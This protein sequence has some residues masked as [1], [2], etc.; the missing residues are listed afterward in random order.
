MDMPTLAT[1]TA[2][3]FTTRQLLLIDGERV[4]SID[5][6]TIEVIDPAT[7][8][9][10]A[11]VAEARAA[12]IDRAVAAARKSFAD[13]RWRGLTGDARARVLLRFAELI[14][15]HAE[16]LA[17]IDT[18][19]NGMPLYM[20]RGAVAGAALQLRAFAGATTRIVGR[21]VS[22]AISLPGEY[23]AYTRR[24]PVGVVGLI[25]PWNGPLPTLITKLAPALASGC[26]LVVKPSEI[27]PLSA[28]RVGELALEA[29]VPA[30]VLNVVP[31]VGGDAGAA[32]ANHGDINKISFT[33]STA[34]GKELV[35]ASAGNLKRI[36]LELGGKSP[37]IVFDDA[38]MAKAIPGAAMSVFMNSGQACIAGSRLFV[39]RKAFDKVVDG[40]AQVA[41]NLKVGNGFEEG[42]DL[43]PLI[44][45]RQRDRV[46]SYIEAGRKE[47][48]EVVTGGDSAGTSG[49]FLNPTVFAN[50]GRDATI[51]REEIFGP[52]IVATPFDDVEELVEV[53]NDTSYGLAAGIFSTNVNTVHKLAARLEAGNVY[54]NGYAMFDPTMP[55]GGMKQ[56]GWGRELGEEGMDAFLE[57]KSVWLAL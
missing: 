46:A 10:I 15:A 57:T 5:G 3:R 36:T 45:A 6:G 34:V 25:T 32:M 1:Q 26:S 37:C 55:F 52:V 42:I 23:H 9:V 8:R 35:R 22:N 44:S 53:A 31:G 20:S 4:D 27:T 17:H 39:E 41:K 12:D 29:G 40:V 11:H 28:L 56:S 16:E 43:G 7:E 21:A 18:L 47:G 30:G 51:M 14:E 50:V 48:G 13:A 19:D 38:D 33:G 49:F 54:V 2:Q 24:E